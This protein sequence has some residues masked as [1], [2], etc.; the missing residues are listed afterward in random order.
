MSTQECFLL[1][2]REWL[3]QKDGNGSSNMDSP[4]PTGKT[5]L[6]ILL[7]PTGLCS[8]CQEQTPFSQLVDFCMNPP[9]KTGN[10]MFGVIA[11]PTVKWYLRL[12]ASVVDHA[13]SW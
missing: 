12:P 5:K 10:G 8:Q 13:L 6:A 11:T 3:T 4:T 1:T 7:S 2:S 9:R